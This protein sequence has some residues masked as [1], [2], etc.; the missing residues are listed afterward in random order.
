MVG[1]RRILHF[2]NRSRDYL[3]EMDEVQKGEMVMA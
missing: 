2:Y 3:G 1:T